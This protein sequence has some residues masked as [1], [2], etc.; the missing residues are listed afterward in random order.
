MNSAKQSYFISRFVILFS[1]LIAVCLGVA[2]W[3][4]N[5]WPTDAETYY[6]PAALRIPHIQYLSEIH[7]TE[8]I[9]KV[10]W[11]HG[12]EFYVVGFSFFQFIL[13]DFESLR[14]LMLLGLISIA[15][16]SILIFYIAR[17]FWGEWIAL[18]CYFA[19]AL[20]FWPYVYIL[21]AK[22][23]TL[24]LMVFLLSVVFLL[25]SIRFRFWA[26]WFLL[27]GLTLGASFFSSTVSSL[28]VFYYL[29]VFLWV[30]FL[31]K[32]KDFG[33]ILKGLLTR[34]LLVVVGAL[35]V[36]VY[37]NLPDIF[38]NIK[39]CAQYVHISGAFN[40]FY[41][42]QVALQQWFPHINVGEIRAGWIWVLKYLFL[43]LPVLFPLYFLAVIYLCIRIFKEKLWVSRVKIFAM[44]LLSGSSP[45]MAEAA[46]VAQYGS[47]YSQL[48]L[49]LL[50]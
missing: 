43:I 15:V 23:Q 20:S 34:G 30:F 10:R 9:E 28:F 29:G 3:N 45:A 26:A 49:G 16:S 13:N 5:P 36:F 39:N 19:F 50:F 12:K 25:N 44:I 46:K 42:N 4:I 11:L 14:P 32:H 7:V 8:G 37:V 27:S 33:S 47:N 41:Y 1:I 38:L 17:R 6:L 31:A 21:F 40:H 48:S 22:H 35:S 18:A 24:G 2:V